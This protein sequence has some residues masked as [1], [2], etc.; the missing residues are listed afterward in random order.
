MAWRPDRWRIIAAAL[1]AGLFLAACGSSATSSPSSGT[2]P[3]APAAAASPTPTSAT[4]QAAADLRDSVTALTHVQIGSGTVDEI[5]SG[6]A[7]V[8]AKLT[9]LKTEL[10]D[11]STAQT[12][13]VQ[14]ALDTLK[15]AISNLSAHPSASAV[16]DGATAV[17]GVTTAVGNLMTS[18]APQCGSATASPSA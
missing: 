17:G 12:S 3:N 6:L 8:Q 14:S 9:A 7:D 18:L 10:H 11:T 4:C 13:A 16:K 2:S 15:T 5:R 1:V